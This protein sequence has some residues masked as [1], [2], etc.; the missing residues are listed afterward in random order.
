M[1]IFNDDNSIATDFLASLAG[2]HVD[3]HDELYKSVKINNLEVA[4]FVKAYFNK[5]TK[6]SAR[7]AAFILI[8]AIKSGCIKTTDIFKCLNMGINL[9]TYLYMK[10]RL[11]FTVN[12]LCYKK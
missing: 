3:K 9:E 7:D 4:L 6:S 2:M 1:K 10:L 8:I 5:I 11:I 12:I